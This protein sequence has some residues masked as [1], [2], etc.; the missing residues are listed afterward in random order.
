MVET[1]GSSVAPVLEELKSGRTRQ[2]LLL[3]QSHPIPAVQDP[4]N[5]QSGLSAEYRQTSAG[6]YA[7]A[8]LSNDLPSL[9]STASSPAWNGL[10]IVPQ[11]SLSSLSG[12]LAASNTGFTSA[13]IYDT[14]SSTVVA[15]K[16]ISSLSGGDTVT[17]TNLSLSAG[18]TYL[19]Q[20]NAGGAS[21]TRAETTSGSISPPFTG[22]NVSVKGSSRGTSASTSSLF[23][24]AA[25]GLPPVGGHVTDSFAAPTAAPASFKAWHSLHAENVSTGTS[26]SSQPVSF[27]ILNSNGTAVNS[28][29]IPLSEFQPFV[30]RGRQAA[31]SASSSGQTQFTIPST[32][33]GGHYGIPILDVVTV[34]HNGNLVNSSNWSFGGTDT[35]TLSNTTINSGDTVTVS[36]DF[37]VFDSTLQ[38]RAYLSRASGSET[39]PSIDHFRYEYII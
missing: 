26:T 23:V 11:T 7:L 34:Q 5:V 36:Y 10:T 31:I 24:F 8:A 18:T 33:S 38:P 16:S 35:V 25:V 27:D 4:M 32:G 20:I 28:T 9:P 22:P 6:S 14:S 39:S 12:R 37:D 13:R 1:G 3:L 21:F 15:S 2:L 19:F 30:M 29:R 17:F